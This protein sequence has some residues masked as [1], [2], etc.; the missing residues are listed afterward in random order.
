MTRRTV[1]GLGL[2]RLAA[3]G[4]V[5]ALLLTTV[6]WWVT[7]ATGTTITAHF[8]RTVGLYAG[9]SVRVL[10]VEVGRVDEVHPS[11]GDV[12]V[13]MTVRRDVDVP[14]SAKAVIVSPS[15]VSGRYVQL[16]PAYDGGPRMP[17][18]TVIPNERT[19]TPA[20][21][22]QLFRNVNELATALGPQGAN[23]GGA[24]SK[25]LDSGAN[26][27]DGNGKQLNAT[28]DRLGRLAATLSD[29][30]GD[31]FSTI[32]NLNTFT[33][34]LAKSDKQ[35]REFYG[36]VA[37]VTTF[38]ASERQETGAAL[39]SLATALADVEK[40][41][42]SNRELVSSNVS[43]LTAVTQALVDQRKA[44]AEVIDVAP[45]GASNFIN[46]YDAKTGAVAVRG[47]IRELAKPP[48]LFV[49]R[50]VQRG[51]PQPLPGEL[52]K[53]CDELAPKLRDKPGLPSVGDALSSLPEGELP[54]PLPGP[55][56]S[57]PSGEG[58]GP[59]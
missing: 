23:S 15:M 5:L 40:F 49:C 58:G 46:A 12:R 11:G 22:D 52:K 26:A 42:K 20:E 57:A 54:L 1:R 28:I 34:T 56:L 16:T 6:I 51:T 37:E 38:L 31:L 24:L 21:L 47:E 17:S 9:S 29:S 27:L 18:G 50:L 32:D 59:R 13:T 19:A 55:A 36:R 39:S 2:T 35:I 8:D 43:N 14:A 10:G 3:L 45:L 4:C 53:A 30:R 48:V 44:L 41:V 33:A 7:S 25:L